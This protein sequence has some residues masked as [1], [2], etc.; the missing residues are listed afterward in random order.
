[1]RYGAKVQDGLVVDVFVLAEGAK[2]D[3]AIKKLGLVEEAG[4]LPGIGW[5]WDGQAFG[6]PPL[7]PATWESIRADRDS[8]LA[9]SDWTQVADAPVDKAAWATYR[10]QLRDIPQTFDDPDEVEWPEEP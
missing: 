2:G 4:V 9:A 10:Q 6:L 7:P 8:R 5:T 1:M 3:Q